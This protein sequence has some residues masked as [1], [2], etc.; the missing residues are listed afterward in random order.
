MSADLI[1]DDPYDAL[2]QSISPNSQPTILNVRSFLV[3]NQG[4]ELIKDKD[5]PDKEMKRVGKEE[6]EKVSKKDEKETSLK[7]YQFLQDIGSGSYGKV[8]LVEKD[9]KKYALKELNKDHTLR[10]GAA[11]LCYAL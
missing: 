7:D 9:G 8:H 1:L 2:N 6:E 3:L 10:V 5:G 4:S 11:P